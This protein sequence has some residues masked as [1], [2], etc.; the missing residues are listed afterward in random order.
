MADKFYSVALGEQ[1]HHQV[2]EGGSTSGEAIEL[3]I[4]D[5]AYAYGKVQLDHA[6]QAIREK[7]LRETNPVA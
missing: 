5:A 2:T 1:R 7:V 6:I 3:R 4:S